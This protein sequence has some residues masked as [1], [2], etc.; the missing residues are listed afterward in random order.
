MGWLNEILSA[1]VY[2]LIWTIL[3][4]G[5]LALIDMFDEVFRFLTG[6]IF[7]LILFGGKKFDIDSIP[8]SFFVFCGV[9]LIIAILIFFVQYLSLLTVDDCNLKER[10]NKAIKSSIKGIFFTLCIP[11][12]FFLG[13]GFLE[14]I[15]D[16]IIKIFGGENNSFAKM[17]YLLGSKNW[18]GTSI[19]NVPADFS[20]PTNLRD[21]N[22]I[23]SILAV[24][25]M[26]YTLIMVGLGIS[27]KIFELYLLFIVGPFYAATMPND[28]GVKMKNW[29][30][31]VI[32]KMFVTIGTTL[33]FSVFIVLL[34][35]LMKLTK[36]IF[37]NALARQ[38]MMLLMLLGGGCFVQTMPSF[39]TSLVGESI[40]A[41]EG[42]LAMRGVMAGAGMLKTGAL[43]TLS[44]VGIGAKANLR[45]QRKN[46][47]LNQR[48]M[49]QTMGNL[50][51]LQESVSEQQGGFDNYSHNVQGRENIRVFD[52][53]VGIIGLSGS[54]LRTTTSIAGAT[55]VGIGGIMSLRHA[56][57]WKNK[58]TPKYNR[59][60][61]WSY[62]MFVSG[63]QNLK[64]N[65]KNTYKKF[66]KP[67]VENTKEHLKHKLKKIEDIQKG[68]KS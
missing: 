49:S 41:A 28:N 8:A 65:I 35:L 5:P 61:K 42:R 16:I 23:V 12:C 7:L 52:R 30:D 59:F 26:C 31:S 48:W 22:I 63:K 54:M 45:K 60:E 43:G 53:G 56:K 11:A 47:K 46:E 33:V 68:N 18:D 4:Q 32:G 39:F 10:I 44:A 13:C 34:G 29:R 17:L 67:F 14:F 2:K 1:T 37:D 57:K 36:E 62:K 38:L 58:K 15:Q 6:K 19:A 40:S 55:A 3:I 27:S 64:T 50:D 25:F 9:A 24:W 20:V 21:Y 51:N 66:N